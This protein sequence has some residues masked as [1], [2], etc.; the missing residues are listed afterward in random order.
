MTAC[1]PYPAF[2]MSLMT[3]PPR[4][5]VTGAAAR[6]VRLVR[7]DDDDRFVVEGGHAVHDA[8][9]SCRRLATEHADSLELVDAFGERE[10]RRHRAEG[11]AAEVEVQARADDAP[12]VGDEP[13]RDGDDARVEE[14]DLVDPDDRRLAL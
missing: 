10:Q 8:L 9:R 14:L 7:S 6:L 13:L 11:L 12:A 5:V 2:G 3:R 4:H 1:P